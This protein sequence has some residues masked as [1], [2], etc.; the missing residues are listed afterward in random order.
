MTP[1]MAVPTV[2]MATP[3][4]YGTPICTSHQVV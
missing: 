3:A 1:P 4:K 2:E